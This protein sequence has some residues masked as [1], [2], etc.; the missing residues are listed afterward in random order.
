LK[1]CYNSTKPCLATSQ[2][3]PTLTLSNS[4]GS[5]EQFRI[6]KRRNQKEVEK[7]R[8][9]EEGEESEME[10]GKLKTVEGID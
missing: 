4:R 9:V 2:R 10:E 3:N 7:N 8:K 5:I 1:I 6:L